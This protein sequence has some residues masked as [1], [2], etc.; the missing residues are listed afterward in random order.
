M[1]KR[2]IIYGV[3][4]FPP[5]GGTSRVVENLMLQLKDKYHI[6][7]YCYKH[8]EAKNHIDG[9]NVVEFRQLAKGSIGSMLY[10]LISSFHIL[11][12]GK[13]DF[14]HAHKT[15]CAIFIPLLRLRFKVIATSHEAPYK[16]DK[17]NFIQKKYF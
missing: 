12:F 3:N 7:I 11:L 16:R 8:P 4:Y 5:K 6:T 10:F 1:K 15:D 17:W 14:I 9:I 13:A 2:M